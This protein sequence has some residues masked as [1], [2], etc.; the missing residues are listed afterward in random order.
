MEQKLVKAF[1]SL[2]DSIISALPNVAVGI[3][4]LVLGLVVAKLVEVGLPHNAGPRAL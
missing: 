1:T 3:L 4:L 2:G